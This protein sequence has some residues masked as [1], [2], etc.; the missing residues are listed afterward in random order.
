MHGQIRL[1]SGTAVTLPNGETGVVE[2]FTKQLVENKVG[3]LR[4]RPVT[5]ALVGGIKRRGKTLKR[6]VAIRINELSF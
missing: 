6:P 5:F 2:G 1:T 3:D 4:G